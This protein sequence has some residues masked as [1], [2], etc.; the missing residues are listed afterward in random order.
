MIVKEVNVAPSLATV[1]TQIVNELTLLTVTNAATNA[2]IHAAITGYRLVNVPSNMVISA[3]GVITW[4]PVQAQSPSTNLITTVV[5]NSDP[6]DLVNPTLTATNTFIRGGQGGERC[7]LVADHC[8]PDRQ[9]SDAA[10]RYQHRDQFQHSFHHSRLYPR[11]CAEQYG[12]QRLGH[13]HLD[14]R[15]GTK[16]RANLITTVVTNSNPYDL[17]NPRLTSTNTFTVVVKEVNS[18][19]TLPIF[20]PRT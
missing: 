11:Q 13:H 16:P 18:A 17:V 2:N 7:A 5:T 1:S 10:H 4:T 6:Y 19:P 8:H 20:P 3:S 9:R 15:T 14:A 12:D